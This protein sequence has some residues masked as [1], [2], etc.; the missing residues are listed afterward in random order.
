[1]DWKVLIIRCGTRRDGGRR[2]EVEGGV[3]LETR[4]LRLETGH[5]LSWWV[6]A[7]RCR[8]GTVRAPRQG[9]TTTEVLVTKY[10]RN[11]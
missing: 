10:I 4:H 5:A 2:E 11:D 8:Y 1:M 7:V 6:Q 9:G 3:V